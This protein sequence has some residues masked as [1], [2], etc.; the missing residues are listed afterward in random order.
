MEKE[1]QANLSQMTMYSKMGR[2]IS[3]KILKYNKKSTT[4]RPRPS[5]P[6][7][8]DYVK[9]KKSLDSSMHSE[10]RS[11]THRHKKVFEGPPVGYYK[12]SHDYV[13]KNTRTYNFNRS[14]PHFYRDKYFCNESE[15]ALKDHPDL[16][17]CKPYTKGLVELKR[18]T[19]RDDMKGSIRKFVEDPH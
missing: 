16:S 3:N 11:T 9:A 13:E 5:Q 17:T 14:V 8:L 4:Q 2:Y 19:G 7:L 6:P 12:V 15:P 10:K 1:I 18:V